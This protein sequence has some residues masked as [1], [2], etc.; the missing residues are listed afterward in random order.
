MIDSLNICV[1]LN[2]WVAA[3]FAEAKG[4]QDTASQSIVA[5][6]RQGSCL[7]QPVQLI[8]SWGMLTRLRQ[9]LIQKLQVST[10]SV[11]LYLDTITAYAQLG[12]L[13][14]SPQLT[15]GGTGIV[16][17]ADIEDAHVL[18]TAIAGKAQVLITA[19]FKD[20]ISKDTSV[21]V[22]QRHA[23]HSTP[24]QSFHIVHPY[25]FLEW[26]RNGSIPETS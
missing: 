8:I 21:I 12:A 5:I 14:S 22:Q 4:R 2:I 15:L 9:V 16:P 24:D 11:E 25:L 7:S 3:L 13:D 10:S 18:E 26:I 23:I 20:F 6:V 19:N 17:I 1:D